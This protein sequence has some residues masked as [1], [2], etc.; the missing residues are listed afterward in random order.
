MIRNKNYKLFVFWVF[1]LAVPVFKNNALAHDVIDY[2]SVSPIPDWVIEQQAPT[3]KFRLSQDRNTSFL[4]VNE[5]YKFTKKQRESFWHVSELLNTSK[6]VEDYSSFDIVFDPSFQRVKIHF[7]RLIRDDEVFNYLNLSDFNLYRYETDRYKL[8]FNGDYELSYIIPDVRKGDII[9]YAY[10]ISGQNP[11]LGSHFSF[12]YQHQYGI[13]VQKIYQ[14]AVFSDD[15]FVATQPHSN[16][17]APL[18]SNKNGYKIYKWELE[19]VDEK[20]VEDKTPSWFFRYPTTKFSSFQSWDE[21]GKFY[22][23]YYSS[24]D[25]TK[26]INSIADKIKSK[27][28]DPKERIRLALKFV[29]SEIRYLGIQIGQGGYIPRPPSTVLKR[30]YGDCKDMALLLIHILK[31]L[32]I[33]AW[34]L[35]VNSNYLGVFDDIIPRDLFDHVIVYVKIN[36]A[37]FFLDPTR[38]EQLGEL[39]T[40]HQDIYDKGL[41]ISDNS[42]GLIDVK[43][44]QPEFFEEHEDTYDIVSEGDTVLLDT[45]STYYKNKADSM[46]NWLKSD[47]IKPI[48][49]SFFEYYELNFP[50]IEQIGTMEIKTYDNDAKISFLASYKIPKAW[51]YKNQGKLKK[52]WIY[53]EDLYAKIPKF[54][55]INRT[56][57]YTIKHPVR[58]KYVVKVFVDDKWSFEDE[59]ASYELDAFNYKMS[60]VFKDNVLTETRSYVTNASYIK[61]EDFSNT[62]LTIQDI[63]KS[64]SLGLDYDVVT[65]K[66]KESIPEK[67]S[68]DIINVNIFWIF[69]TLTLSI[70]F[71]NN[72]K[73][74]R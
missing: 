11:A 30:R 22:A 69:I 57:P 23:P 37:E 58:V 45:V 71:Y 31:A 16:A 42:N 18:I 27:S 35:L 19:D 24:V 9:E 6:G 10:T 68:Q 8:Q 47:G 61:P 33:E 4:L 13:P 29:Q 1:L 59:K 49:K 40:L 7:L 53:P 15:L 20:I 50:S 66:D 39:E 62:M 65:E 28:T 51:K 26:E 21:I 55:G 56:M 64:L 34:P 32:D 2:V 52:L 70:I 60:S 38:G 12:S 48:E 72:S 5:Q 25:I 46:K 14:R 63:R 3:E 73:P 54:D 17:P 44:N 67:W 43:P 74:R 41:I 36:G